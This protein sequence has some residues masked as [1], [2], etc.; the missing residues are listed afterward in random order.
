M[1]KKRFELKKKDAT[2]LERQKMYIDYHVNL[3]KNWK[4]FKDL[5]DIELVS[6]DNNS[7]TV[8]VN[9]TDTK[10]HSLFARE[11]CK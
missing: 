7:F 9:D 8:Q 6:I 11:L 3:K 2:F 5:I 10:W 1:T 4:N